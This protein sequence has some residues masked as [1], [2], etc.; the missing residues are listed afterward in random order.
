VIHAW[1]S[2]QADYETAILDIIRCGGDTDTR[3]AIVGG[4]IGA[5][6]GSQGIPQQWLNDLWA[7]PRTVN[8]MEKLAQ[9]L[10]QV[11]CY[12]VKQKPL[13]ISI[14]AGFLR[15]IVFLLIVLW[16]GFLRALPPY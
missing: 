5:R 11:C 16:H 8:W 13:P 10:N 9:R 4:I 6:V 7:F 14:M 1:L 3:A 15:N 12:D 2:N